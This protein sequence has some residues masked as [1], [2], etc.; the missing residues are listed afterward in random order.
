MARSR[1]TD[2]DSAQR[3]DVRVKETRTTRYRNGNGNGL[4][5]DDSEGP[6]A[7]QDDYNQ[8]TLI[9]WTATAVTLGI[10][11][12]LMILA[13]CIRYNGGY[14]WKNPNYII[15][16]LNFHPTFQILAFLVIAGTC[17]AWKH[18]S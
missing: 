14:D 17:K 5:D 1:F 16:T 10:I 12:F 4:G 3:V 18:Q 7:N 15:G 8:K 2:D 13:W 6:S 11:A 9:W